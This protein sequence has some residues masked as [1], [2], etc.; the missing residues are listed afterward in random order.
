MLN[1]ICFG[2]LEIKCYV[3]EHKRYSNFFVQI[4]IKAYQKTITI[5]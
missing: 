3:V 4:R 5:F 1:G 2:K